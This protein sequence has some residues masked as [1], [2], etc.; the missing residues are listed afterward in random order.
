MRDI[1]VV[2]LASTNEF[3]HLWDNVQETISSGNDPL[4]SNYIDLDPKSFVSFPV[5]IKNNKII[6]F[7][8]LQISEERW[9]HGI[10][11]CSARMWVDPE[12]RFKNLV[13]FSGG[14][15]F[16]NTTY[17]LPLQIEVAK[18]HKFSTIFISREN[19]LLG[20]KEYLKLI[21][22]NCYVDFILESVRYNICGPK[23][24]LPDSCKQHVAVL[25]L[26]DTGSTLWQHQM[27]KYRIEQENL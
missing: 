13:R 22:I 20:F 12:Y 24:F 23:S 15:R 11:R 3:N 4:K 2:D 6:C 17:I 16:L 19:N 10:G 18:Q 8:G 5:V 25:H 7:S 14:N 26:T 1:I 27:N 9:G 21:K